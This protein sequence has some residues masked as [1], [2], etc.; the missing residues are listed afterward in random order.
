[1]PLHSSLGDKSKTL[2]QVLK[3]EIKGYNL[4]DFKLEKEFLDMESKAWF[5]G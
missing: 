5:L 2:S 1:M 4:G 3:K